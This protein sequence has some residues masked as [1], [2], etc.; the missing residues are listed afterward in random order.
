MVDFN[1]IC[2][3][4]HKVANTD[5]VCI[6]DFYNSKKKLPQVRLDLKSQDQESN[7]HP[8]ELAGHVFVSL[9]D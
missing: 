9:F 2:R 7:T 8:T 3:N 5:N 6:T 4:Q 1:K